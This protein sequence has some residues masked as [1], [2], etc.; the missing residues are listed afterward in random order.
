MP[1]DEAAA[2][3]KAYVKKHKLNHTL[4]ELFLAITQNKPENP[5]EFAFKHFESKLPPPPP[6]PEPEPEPE[7]IVPKETSLLN[8]TNALSNLSTLVKQ[9]NVLNS[10]KYLNKTVI[11]I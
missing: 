6:Q 2:L 8:L 4:N 5:I 1:T 10:F 3:E 9:L 7:P 11:L